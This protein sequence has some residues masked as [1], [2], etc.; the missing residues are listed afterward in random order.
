MRTII[1][2]AY[3]C[4]CI[5]AAFHVICV[6]KMASSLSS[7]SCIPD[8]PHQPRGFPFPKREYGKT[9]VA[10]RSFRP[11]W[12]DKWPWLHYC[13]ENDSVVCHTCLLAKSE[14]KHLWSSNA[15]TALIGF[16]NW[17]DATKKFPI[18]E[19]TICTHWRF[20]H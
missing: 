13:E 7:A 16:S 5:R 6:S 10:K 11:S 12:F 17:K 15:D 14:R 8:K 19:A 2:S 4:Y 9:S 3:S 1:I 18:H 20:Y